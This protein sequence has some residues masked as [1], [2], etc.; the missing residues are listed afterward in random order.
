MV[1]VD[2]TRPRPRPENPDRMDAAGDNPIKSRIW[3]DLYNIGAAVQTRRHVGTFGLDYSAPFS[4]V[5]L[6]SPRFS[7]TIYPN[8]PSRLL[9]TMSS[10]LD[11]LVQ[12]GRDA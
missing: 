11:P 4:P 7:P 10:E 5:W 6:R 3:I 9:A 12:F 1:G 2:V 8:L